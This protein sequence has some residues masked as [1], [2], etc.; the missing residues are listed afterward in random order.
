MG[1]RVRNV[2]YAS[3]LILAAFIVAGCTAENDDKSARPDST[4][5]AASTTPSAAATG[6]ADACPVTTQTLESA[7][8]ADAKFGPKAG[9]WKLGQ[10]VCYKGFASAPILSD[11]GGDPGYM[12]FGHD[13]EKGTWRPLN[14]GSARYCDGHVPAEIA[15]HFPGCGT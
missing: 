8:Q 10:P 1:Q 11:F 14:N 4:P 5:T 3:S 2:V 9:S 7:V 12:L 6:G 13:A 15:S